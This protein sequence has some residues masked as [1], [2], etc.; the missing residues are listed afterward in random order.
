[1]TGLNNTPNKERKLSPEER[2]GFKML[3]KDLAKTFIIKELEKHE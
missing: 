3:L 1:M 2:E